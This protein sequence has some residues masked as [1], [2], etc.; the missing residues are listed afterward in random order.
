MIIAAAVVLWCALG[1][2]GWYIQIK[3]L[4]L[5]SGYDALMV[6]PMM[7]MGPIGLWIVLTRS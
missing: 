6:G 3:R 2:S 7:L 5:N 1:Y 4:N